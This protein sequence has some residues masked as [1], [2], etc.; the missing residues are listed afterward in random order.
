MRRVGL[1]RRF[2]WWAG[3]EYSFVWFVVPVSVRRLA[4]V[5]PYEVGV[6]FGV[7]AW[8]EGVVAAVRWA[9]YFLRDVISPVLMSCVVE[10]GRVWTIVS[11]WAIFC[12]ADNVRLVDVVLS[13]CV[14]AR[15]R[16][17]VLGPRG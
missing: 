15:F 13:F 10:L 3:L 14:Q 5:G 1:V 16:S 11:V 17:C 12:V 2:V 4:R 7:R 9:V 6:T 8:C